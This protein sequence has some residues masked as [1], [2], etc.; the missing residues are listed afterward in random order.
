M[1]AVITTL[2]QL[3][4]QMGV[5]V[6][7][8]DLGRRI[9]ALSEQQFQDFETLQKPYPR[10]YRQQ[11]LIGLVFWQEETV[12]QPSVWFL[13]LPL[14]EQ[15]LLLPAERDQ[16]LQH[17]LVAIGNNLDAAQ[18]NKQLCAVLEGN[19]YVYTPT[20]EKQ[21]AFNAKMKVTLQ[22][23]PSQFFTGT[24]K[25]LQSNDYQNWQELALQ[26]IADVAAQWAQPECQQALL[27]SLPSLPAEVF[28][29]LC[30]CLENE[31][32]DAELSAALAKRLDIEQQSSQ[33]NPAIIAACLRGLSYSVAADIIQNAVDY[34]LHNS[35]ELDI[36]VIATLATRL[37]PQLLNG[38]NPLVF[39]ELLAQH[40]EPSFIGVMSELLY[41]PILRE[42]FLSA[43][44]LPEVS[45]ALTCAINALLRPSQTVH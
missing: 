39:M 41:Q 40:P 33:P 44:R 21:A 38:A 6:R 35:D 29:S 2:G 34:T 16:F 32:I 30:Q 4:Q 45:A 23:P 17:L 43:M 28:V 12:T 9:E 36:E 5:Q 8:Y 10:P 7:L 14:D 22:L 42:P 31:A 27:K 26:G 11:A 1:S 13:R 19:P 25:Y 24:L 15:G 18:K 37:G 3:L 20:Q